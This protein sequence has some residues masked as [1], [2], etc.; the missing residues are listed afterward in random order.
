MIRRRV[1][2]AGLA[3]SLAVGRARA[4]PIGGTRIDAPVPLWTVLVGAGATVGVTAGV[5]AVAGEPT[6]R[7]GTL[8]TVPTKAV[9]RVKRAAAVAFLVAVAAAVAHGLA[10]PQ[11]PL[12][13]L[14]TL[15]VWSIWVKG[16][17][18]IAILTGS[19]WRALSPW[20]T[21]YRGLCRLEGGSI[22]R[23]QYPS[24]LDSWPALVGILALVGVVDNLTVLPQSPAGTA[25][26]V[27]VYAILMLV[28]SL[29]FGERWFARADPLEVLYR[30][31]GRAAPFS[32]ERTD[33]GDG[34]QT[35]LVARPPWQE[36]ARPVADTALA[37]VVVAAVYTVSFDGFA[38]TATYQTVLFA[39]RDATGVGPAVGVV[40][41]LT[42]FGV[43]LA[44]F[45]IVA[46]L[47]GRLGDID[48]SGL[49][50]APT[51]LP[52]AAAYELAHNY[53]YVLG[54]AGRL[55]AVVGGHAVDSLAW[56]SI[57][58]F[59]TSQVLL[60]VGGHLVAVVAA[61]RVV[62]TGGEES[63][64]RAHAPLAVLMIG[65]TVLSLWIVSQPIVA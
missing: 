34:D 30:L 36:T 65:F 21:L 47:V 57:P 63:V 42:G 6:V 4:H 58:A 16:V 17:G 14:A 22:G 35:R 8:T 61:H 31:L 33:D 9:E 3:L 19:P 27:A 51:V 44:T 50:I 59:W 41:Y 46:T 5:I 45:W 20:R 62:E 53:P 11:T 13:N 64:L 52:I 38:V 1:L 7:T 40:L 39:V 49:A 54:T 10:G 12:S 23:W 28:G 56:L 60:I 37:A 32:V 18:L 25:R 29:A 48:A 26:V 24:M 2:V 55:P 15:F 43:F